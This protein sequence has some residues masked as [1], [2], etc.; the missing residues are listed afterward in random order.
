MNQRTR[1]FIARCCISL[2]LFVNLQ[3]A[4]QFLIYPHHYQ[5]GFELLGTSGSAFIQ[6]MGLLF[7]MWNVP[8]IFALFQPIQNRTSLIEAIIMQLIGVIGETILLNLLTGDH[9]QL[10]TTIQRFIQFDGFGLLSLLTAFG[11][12]HRIPSGDPSAPVNPKDNY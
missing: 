11:L 7:I 10:H 9:F 12:T 5:P 1:L 4:I 6:G 2:V 3:C 8:Y